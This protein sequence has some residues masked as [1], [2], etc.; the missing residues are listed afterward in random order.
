M[1]ILIDLLILLLIG[2]TAW[3]GWKKGVIVGLCGLL[4]L[5]ISIYGAHI[6]AT[7]YYTEYTQILDPFIS[8]YMDTSTT[9]V[10]QDTQDETAGDAAQDDENETKPYVILTDEE[11]KD[12]YSVTYAAMRQCGVANRAAEK[13]AAEFAGQYTTV[14]NTLVD[15]MGEYLTGRITYMILFAVGFILIMTL[16]TILENVLNLTFAMPGIEKVNRGLGAAV[17]AIRAICLL[18]VVCCV[19]RYLG[20]FLGNDR[21]S[22]TWIFEGMINSNLI[23]NILGV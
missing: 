9:L 20:L 2:L 5:V 18:L 1:H 4:A 6:V 17:G 7:A 11:K 22:A 23:A 14:D 21:I 15:A 3:R 12:V 8:G 10:T 16:F 13:I 19:C